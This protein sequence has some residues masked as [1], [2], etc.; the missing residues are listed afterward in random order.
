[1]PNIN[2]R[3]TDE[4]HAQ[5]ERWAHDGYRSI[6]KEIIFRLFT[7]E[8]GGRPAVTGSAPPR[9]DSVPRSD[10]VRTDFK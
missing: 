7:L 9:S 8:R 10:D 2:L 3:L 5:L 1:M 6:Q 4:Q